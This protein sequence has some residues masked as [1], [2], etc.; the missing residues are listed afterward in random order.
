M[1]IEKFTDEN[2]SAGSVLVRTLES[3]M[4]HAKLANK[5]TLTTDEIPI[6]NDY[7]ESQFTTTN[8]FQ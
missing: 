2:Q 4:E 5:E 1:S 6:G 8:M 7:L 3:Y